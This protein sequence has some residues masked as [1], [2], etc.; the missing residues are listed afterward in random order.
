MTTRFTS[1]LRARGKRR[2]WQSCSSSPTATRPE[3]ANRVTGGRG[4][5]WAA[6]DMATD[7]AA[8]R[9]QNKIRSIVPKWENDPGVASPTLHARHI[10]HA[11]RSAR[12]TER[13]RGAGE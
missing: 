4:R 7:R 6:V 13:L 12:A 10:R 2:R 11:V 8:A 3:V 1:V 9:K 5:A